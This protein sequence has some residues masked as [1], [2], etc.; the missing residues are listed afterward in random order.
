M[1]R[2]GALA[3]H[4]RVVAPLGVRG[5]IS[6]AFSVGGCGWRRRYLVLELCFFLKGGSLIFVV[7]V[8]VLSPFFCYCGFCDCFLDGVVH[9]PSNGG[10][11]YLYSCILNCIR[12]YM[13][14]L[15]VI[16]VR[17]VAWGSLVLN[18]A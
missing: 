6:E 15:I 8:R 7:R 16:R 11:Y 12:M 2:P 17:R 18:G 13:F 10:V 3:F 4:V 14:T 1:Y 5:S 9:L